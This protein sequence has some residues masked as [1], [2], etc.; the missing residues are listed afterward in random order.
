MVD[1]CGETIDL[2]WKAAFLG[3]VSFVAYNWAIK[4]GVIS[5]NYASRGAKY[6]KGRMMRS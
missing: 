6:L 3:A 1:T 2:L 4:E 5:G